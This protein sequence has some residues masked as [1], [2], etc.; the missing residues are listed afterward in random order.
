MRRSLCTSG[1][2]ERARARSPRTRHSNPSIAEGSAR[3]VKHVLQRLRRAPPS[4]R[5]M[6]TCVP[7]LCCAHR[8]PTGTPHIS[9]HG[10]SRC[11]GNPCTNVCWTIGP[12][13][14]DCAATPIVFGAGRICSAA[15]WLGPTSVPERPWRAWGTQCSACGMLANLAWRG[16]S[17]WYDIATNRCGT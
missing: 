12:L 14:H 16:A 13:R 1:L 9:E 2:A 4:I 7:S 11:S 6:C 5:P 3:P 8:V 10:V 15:V 17:L